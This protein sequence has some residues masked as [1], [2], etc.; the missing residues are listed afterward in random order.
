MVNADIENIDIEKVMQ[1]KKRAP[2]KYIV[3]SV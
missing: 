1:A 3:K 2:E